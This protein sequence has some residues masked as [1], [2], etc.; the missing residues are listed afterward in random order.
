MLRKENELLKNS[1]EA[2]EASGVCVGVG[3]GGREGG[4]VGGS[5][6][7]VLRKENELLLKHSIEAAEASGGWVGG[8]W[9]QL[10]QLWVRL[11]LVPGVVCCCYWSCEFTYDEQ[12]WRC[13]GRWVL[14]RGGRGGR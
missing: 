4:C 2:A 3:V 5:P 1:I 10:W 8:L 7:E 6:L 12:Q 9:W 11:A 13:R 14:G